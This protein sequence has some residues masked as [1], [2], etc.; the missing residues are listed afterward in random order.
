MSNNLNLFE[1]EP[2]YVTA[3]ILIHFDSC[4]ELSMSKELDDIRWSKLKELLFENRIEDMIIVSNH[5]G[6]SIKLQQLKAEVTPGDRTSDKFEYDWIELPKRDNNTT[7]INSIDLIQILAG[8]LNCKITNVLI[9]GQNLSGCVWNSL[10]YSA[11]RWLHRQIPVTILLS[12][13]GDYETSGTGPLKYIN[14]FATLYRK[15]QQSG[16]TNIIKLVSD[17]THIDLPKRN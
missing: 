17:F 8:K 7:Q 1:V 14:S 12:M 15:I 2:K 5:L 16:H 11:L 13:C 10:D 3:L 9:A 4:G 6:D